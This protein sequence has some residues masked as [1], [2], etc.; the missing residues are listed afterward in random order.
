MIDR[1]SA[2]TVICSDYYH[3]PNPGSLDQRPH[4]REHQ[5]VKA[6]DLIAI[7]L[8]HGTKIRSLI[9][10]RPPRFTGRTIWPELVGLMGRQDVQKREDGSRAVRQRGERRQLPLHLSHRLDV[11]WHGCHL[12]A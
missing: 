6:F 9:A 5:T 8:A 1:N 10:E 11:V 4:G 3:R 12:R 7:G 2:L